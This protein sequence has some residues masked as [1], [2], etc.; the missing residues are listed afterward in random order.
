MS[1]R[2]PDGRGP[3]TGRQR[4]EGRRPR[5]DD[6]AGGVPFVLRPFE[7]LTDETDWVALREFVPA[8]T[9][10]V[11]LRPG[12]WPAPG[13]PGDPD[14]TV[15]IASVLP[16]AKAAIARTDGLVWL[17]LQTPAAGNSGDASREIA[18]ALQRALVADPGA[19][20][21]AA[22]RLTPGPRLQDLLDLTV[23]LAVEVHRDLAFWVDGADATDDEVA[24]SLERATQTLAPTERIVAT[25]SAYWTRIGARTYVRWVL[26]GGEEESLDAL[27]RLHAADAVRLTASSRLLGSFRSGG[28]LVPVWE[29]P[30]ET[31][32]AELAEP[33]LAAAARLGDART[34][35][36]L[37]D[38]QRRSRAGLLSRQVTLH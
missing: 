7:G 21:D 16:L 3:G 10:T 26:P 29:V 36:P 28:L 9:G 12:A 18:D 30:P 15:R 1:H 34:P 4:R 31:P 22:D 2:G 27:A 24:A 33:V 17:G 23:P 20:I 13:V 8:A 37:T 19:S 6:A 35:G 14:R 32:V 11:A 25:E 38:A 5:R